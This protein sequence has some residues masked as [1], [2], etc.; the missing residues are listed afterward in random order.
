V[1][2]I[3]PDGSGLRPI[4]LDAGPGRYFAYGPVRSPDGTRIVLRLFLASTGGQHLYSVRP[5]GSDLRQV[6]NTQGSEE[7]ADEG[8][9]PVGWFEGLGALFTYPVIKGRLCEPAPCGPP[10]SP[11][12]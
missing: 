2:V 10:A 9:A 11:G 12:H 4:R 1:F 8:T 7:F 3:H 5:T 6:A